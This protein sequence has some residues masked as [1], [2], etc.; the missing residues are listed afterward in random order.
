VEG[1][2]IDDATGAVAARLKMG[3]ISEYFQKIR[4]EIDTV[5]GCSPPLTNDAGRGSQDILGAAGI[6]A[7]IIQIEDNISETPEEKANG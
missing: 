4:I 1:D 6:E 2:V 5:R 7:Q 3:W